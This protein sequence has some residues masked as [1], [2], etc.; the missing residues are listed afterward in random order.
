MAGHK[1]VGLSLDV[2]AVIQTQA[3]MLRSDELRHIVDMSDYRFGRDVV[4]AKK[5]PY[6]IDVDYTTGLCTGFDQLIRYVARMIMHSP[7]IGMRENDR[8][9]TVFQRIHGGTVSGVRAA[10]DHSNPLHLVD[11]TPA[12]FAQS[13]ISLIVTPPAQAV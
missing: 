10:E 7:W 2:K 3:D 8:V 1:A 5:Q 13:R 4:L 6:S 11:D 12:E 9:L